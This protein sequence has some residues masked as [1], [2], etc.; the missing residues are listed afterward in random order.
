MLRLVS[1]RGTRTL[2]DLSGS[3]E[4]VALHPREPWLAVRRRD[5]I[6]IVDLN[7]DLLLRTVR[8]EG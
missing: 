6:D 2:T 1:P 3:T 7:S 8:D 5:A 4:Q